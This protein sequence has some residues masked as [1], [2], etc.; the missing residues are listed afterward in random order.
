M[1][2]EPPQLFQT[3]AGAAGHPRVRAL[4]V[5]REEVA[6]RLCVDRGLLRPAQDAR[7]LAKKV[8]LR[9]DGDGDDA[10][11]LFDHQTAVATLDEEDRV[12]RFPLAKDHLA[13]GELHPADP[14]PA[15][16]QRFLREREEDRCPLDRA[17]AWR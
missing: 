14:P 16:A 9:Q 3:V 6:L 15:C 8:A 1:P 5:K 17:P 2:G 10:R 12:A 11:W 4:P 7:A 13:G